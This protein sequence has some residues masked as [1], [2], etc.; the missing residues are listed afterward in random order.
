MNNNLYRNSLDLYK[1][2]VETV[3][4]D[5]EKNWFYNKLGIKAEG[6]D[7]T[8][9][10]KLDQKMAGERDGYKVRN[11]RMRQPFPA[12]E[13]FY[14]VK[15]DIEQSDLYRKVFKYMP[16]G[17]L[18]HVHSSAALSVDKLISLLEN[19]SGQ[20]SEEI[21]VVTNQ[22]DNQKELAVG[23]LLYKYQLEGKKA[24]D[25]KYSEPLKDFLK[26]PYDKKWL[27][28]LLSFGSDRIMQYPYRW[29][30]FNTI[31][32]RTCRLFCDSRFYL[33]YHVEF[34][35]ECMEDNIYYVELRCGFEKFD[36]LM[37]V[38]EVQEKNQ[39]ELSS[40]VHYTNYAYARE[41]NLSVEPWRPDCKFLDFIC[42]AKDI[43]NQGKEKKIDVR[44]ILN[45]RRSLNPEQDK[46]NLL[47]KIDTAIVMKKIF[48]EK[49]IPLIIG[50]DFVSEEDRGYPTSEYADNIIYSNFCEGYS[51][52]YTDVNKD[53]LNATRDKYRP[54]SRIDKIDFYLHDGESNWSSNT[55]VIDA[56]VISRHRVGH[57]FNMSKHPGCTEDIT[58][59][60]G[61]TNTVICEPVL[62][63][64]PISNQLLGYY[65]DLRNHSAY[66]LMKQGIACCLCSDDPQL[67]GNPGL[68]YDFWEAYVG[69]GVSLEGIKGLVFTAYY[70]W[71]NRTG[72][73]DEQ[74]V[75][76]FINE[77][78]EFLQKACRE[79]GI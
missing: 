45:A 21:Y 10:N 53:F 46:D 52:Q 58:R 29:D 8:R 71:K 62:E 70:F 47:S 17:G 2:A 24:D 79:M 44:V 42:E 75:R 54:G 11:E 3:K 19:W 31:F 1:R 77:W 26:N 4:K 74:I 36:N 55:N 22:D 69:M 61:V 41:M 64:C 38:N 56:A 43:A 7:L 18:L 57:G 73:T 16:K 48:E 35:K 27:K 67:F 30:E 76:D 49:G 9:E 14:K 13:P 34:F 78:N 50:F 40:P 25:K 5:N 65:P 60:A 15:E 68:S 12:S 33:Q 66:Q 72:F 6:E 23:T 51:V 20:P 39:W 28:E 63:I 59:I 37:T 32:S